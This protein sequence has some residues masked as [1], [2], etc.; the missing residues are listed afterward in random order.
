M[1]NKITLSSAP[2]YASLVV[3]TS[4]ATF[5]GS[6]WAVNEYQAYQESVEIIKYNYKHQ[7]ESR[8][9]EEL[10][11]VVELIDHLQ[12]QNDL[13]VEH[14]IRERVQAAYTIASHNYQLYKDEKSPDELRSMVIELLRPMRWNSGRGYYFLGRVNNGIIDLFADEPFF[15]GKSAAEFKHSLAKMSSAILSPQSGRKKPGSFVIN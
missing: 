12:W 10:D 6:F 11:K 7:Y 9:K 13:R 3:I 4:L 15:E 1:F 14:D 5:I 8:L 2:F